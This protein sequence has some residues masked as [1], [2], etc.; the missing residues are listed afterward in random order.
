MH[1]L[2]DGERFGMAIVM[3]VPGRCDATPDGR[4]LPDVRRLVDEF[5][6]A[7]DQFGTTIRATKWCA[8]R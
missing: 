3:R 1:A 6:I 7:L 2:F 8:R 5:D 4:A